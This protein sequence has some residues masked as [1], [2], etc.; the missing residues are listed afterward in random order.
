VQKRLEKALAEPTSALLDAAT[1]DTW[2]AIKKLLTQETQTVTS[3]LLNAVSGFDMDKEEKENMLSK[4]HQTGRLLIEKKASD[5]ANQALIRM[6]ERYNIND[7]LVQKLI[8][9]SMDPF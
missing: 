9:L 4:L 5:E 7:M 8:Q 3:E 2:P 6:K 1:P